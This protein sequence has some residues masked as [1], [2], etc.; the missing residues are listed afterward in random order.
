MPN[1]DEMIKRA[2]NKLQNHRA[3]ARELKLPLHYVMLI[4]GMMSQEL[5]QKVNG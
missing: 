5:F 2:Y 1:A 4:L 3:V